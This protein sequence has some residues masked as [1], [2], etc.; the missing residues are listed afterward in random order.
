VCVLCFFRVIKFLLSLAENEAAL[1]LSRNTAREK[2][3]TAAPR[4]KN[5]EK[6]LEPLHPLS[7][8]NSINKKQQGGLAAKT[9]CRGIIIVHFVLKG[10]EQQENQQYV[11][12]P[13]Q[14]T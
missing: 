14:R 4:T 7:Q 9:A 11:E 6:C 2:H 3:L 1:L 8:Y 12:T 5:R 10:E 13:K